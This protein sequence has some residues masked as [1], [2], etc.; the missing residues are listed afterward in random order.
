MNST[1]ARA[2]WQSGKSSGGIILAMAGSIFLISLLAEKPEQEHSSPGLPVGTIVAFAG[3]PSAVPEGWLLCDGRELPI[4]QYGPLFAALEYA[5]GRGGQGAFRVPD[6]RGRFLRGVDLT[7]DL[8]RRDP[9]RDHRIPAYPGGNSGNQ[10]GSIQEDALALHS[11]AL[12]GATRAVGMADAASQWLRFY[13]TQIEA[14]NAPAI[15]SGTAILP[16][17]GS[18]T[19][20]KNA[21]VHWIIKVH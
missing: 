21:N 10:A 6:L 20:P 5:W 17:G 4:Q 13:G 19:R 2:F 15:V 8:E 11:H 16:A 7:P 3:A 14:D 12:S 1:G 9:D 18:E